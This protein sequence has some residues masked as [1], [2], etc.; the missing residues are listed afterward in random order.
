MT[1]QYG[2]SPVDGPAPPQQQSTDSDVAAAQ[3]QLLLTA[4]IVVYDLLGNE[5]ATRDAVV[6]LAQQPVRWVPTCVSRPGSCRWT[7]PSGWQLHRTGQTWT[8]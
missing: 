6:Q 7:Q 8:W 2:D 1:E 3:K 4:D 5:R